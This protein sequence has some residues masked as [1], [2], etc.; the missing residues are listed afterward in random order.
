MQLIDPEEL[1]PDGGV[2]PICKKG[3]KLSIANVC[4]Y[5]G[6]QYDDSEN[7]NPNEPSGMNGA[8]SFTAYKKEYEKRIKENPKYIWVKDRFKKKYKPSH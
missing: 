3:P 5:C 7:E 1:D 2:C 8:W 4:R 6:W